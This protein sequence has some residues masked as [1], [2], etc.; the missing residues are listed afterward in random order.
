M[1]DYTNLYTCLCQLLH[2]THLK[3]VMFSAHPVTQNV[4]AGAVLAFSFSVILVALV[5]LI[6][7]V[8]FFLPLGPDLPAQLGKH[9]WKLLLKWQ[10]IVHR[11]L[12]RKPQNKHAAK[13]VAGPGQLKQRGDCRMG[14]CTN[15]DTSFTSI[16][17][18]HTHTL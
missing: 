3:P 15:R 10:Q 16:E 9:E 18:V 14:D 17:K 6:A 4:S 8:D 13:Q 5:I 12:D 1:K 11:L 2:I 7:F